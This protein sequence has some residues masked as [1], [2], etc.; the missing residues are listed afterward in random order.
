MI[1]GDE[2]SIHNLKLGQYRWALF[3]GIFSIVAIPEVNAANTLELTAEI[4]NAGECDIAVSPSLIEFKRRPSVGEFAANDAV[5]IQLL[6]LSYK[7]T[8]YETNAR[9]EIKVT[10]NTAADTNLFLTA[11]PKGAKGVGFMLKDGAVKELSG[12]YN[13]GKTVV[14]GDSVL[15]PVGDNDGEKPFTVGFIRQVGNNTVTAGAVKAAILF[16]VVMP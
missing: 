15:L 3:A 8:G 4:D 5:D 6:S 2:V 13:A 1:L 16:T 7:C 10:G 14:N 11:D 12:Y 9:P